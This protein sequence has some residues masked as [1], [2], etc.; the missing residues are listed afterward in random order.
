MDDQTLD[1]FVEVL[2]QK[3]LYGQFIKWYQEN[4]AKDPES[5]PLQLAAYEWEDIFLEF[6]SG[7]DLR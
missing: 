7:V 4:H 5:W 2:R 3:D 6:L 1:G